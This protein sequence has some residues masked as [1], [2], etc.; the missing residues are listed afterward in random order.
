ML[1]WTGRLAYSAS[2]TSYSVTLVNPA[3]S[4]TKSGVITTTV[5][6]FTVATHNHTLNKDQ[7][8][9]GTSTLIINCIS[10]NKIMTAVHAGGSFPTGMSLSVVG[11]SV[12]LVGTP[13]VANTYIFTVAIEDDHIAGSPASTHAGLITIT[14]SAPVVPHYVNS[15]SATV[16]AGQQINNGNLNSTYSGLLADVN[17][18]A[19]ITSTGSLTGSMPAGVSYYISGNRIY[20]ENTPT[21]GS[22]GW[23]SGTMDVSYG[24]TIYNSPGTENISWFIQVVSP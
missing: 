12:Y 16:I 10:D 7:A 17:T 4:D 13:T 24:S 22:V 8:Y 3:G 2:P 6:G 9:T 23:Y 5:G 18:G 1:I 15:I 11:G 14:V 19:A 20:L 21:I